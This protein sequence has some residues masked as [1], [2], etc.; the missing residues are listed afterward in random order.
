MY[1][2]IFS[3]TRGPRDCRTKQ[4]RKRQMS[5]DISYMWNLKYATN[6]PICETET[7]LQT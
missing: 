7:D 2:A 3:N 4:V 5:Y 6:E 1:N